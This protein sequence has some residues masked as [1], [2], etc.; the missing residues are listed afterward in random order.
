VTVIS[1]LL[2]VVRTGP[3]TAGLFETLDTAEEAYI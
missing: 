3:A 1:V 2:T